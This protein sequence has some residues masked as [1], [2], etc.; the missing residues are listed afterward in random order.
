[1]SPMAGGSG[2]VFLMLVGVIIVIAFSE[3][4][5]SL[6][7]GLEKAIP[8][9]ILIVLVVIVGVT[10]PKSPKTIASLI[11]GMIGVIV[12][13]VIPESIP[14]LILGVVLC[15]CNLFLL[16]FIKLLAPIGLVNR[17]SCHGK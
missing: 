4:I 2:L 8:Y 12:V 10:I 1:M 3:A 11:L 5:P 17:L 7:L 6:L 13:V 15:K 9:L 14:F 16:A